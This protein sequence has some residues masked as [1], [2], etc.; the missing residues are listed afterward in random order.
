MV[1][2]VY[3][4]SFDPITN[5][6]LDIVQRALSIFHRLTIAVLINPQKQP[7]F[8]I[9]ERK[10][11]IRNAVLKYGECVQVDEFRGLLVDYAVRKKA[12]AILRGLRAVSDFEFEFQISLMN[13]KLQPGIHTVYLMASKD[14]TYLSSGLVKEVA[15]LGGDIKDLVPL[16]VVQEL[17]KKCQT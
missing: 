15:F 1:H 10:Q 4:G 16:C 2:A 17:K 3:P 9:E 13:Q 12:S 11:M 14:F 8:T 5:G 6:H 7:L